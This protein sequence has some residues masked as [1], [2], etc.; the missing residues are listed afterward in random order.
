MPRHLLEEPFQTA[1]ATGDTIA[2]LN[3]SLWRDDFVGSGPYRIERWDPGIEVD[4]RSFDGFALGKPA[5]DQLKVR[6]IK[7]ANV[8]ISNLLSGSIDLAYNPTIG[9]T[10]GETLLE[11]DWPGKVDFFLGTTPRYLHFQMRTWPNTQLAVHDVRVRQALIHAVDRQSIVDGIYSG[12]TVPLD[13]WLH[14]SDQFF[15][16]VER[17]ISKYPFDMA[18]AQALLD[19]AGWQRAGDGTLRNAAG[20]ALSMPILAHSGRI[21]E[22]ETEVIASAWRTL[23]MSADVSWLTPQQ[24]RDGEFRSKFPAVTYDRRGLQMV[25]TSDQVAGPDNRWALGNRNGYANPEFDDRWS[26]YVASASLPDRERYLVEAMKILTADAA[27]MPTHLQPRIVARPASLTGIKD[28]AD[29]NN[30]MSNTWE[31]R[32][33]EAS[34]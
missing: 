31:W 28:M 23:G 15:Q 11:S 17:A 7:D 20:E 3:S 33:E 13:V 4:F 1:V 25:W 24:M 9:Y 32:W 26:R 19:Q 30:N 34:R 22:Q 16:S 8:V 12:R 29:I 18:R 10:Q 2:F 6:F 27:I 21:E 14:P 5:I